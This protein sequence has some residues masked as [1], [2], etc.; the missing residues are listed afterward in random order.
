MLQ[1]VSSVS[2]AGRRVNVHGR[3]PAVVEQ[4]IASVG[5]PLNAHRVERE[6]EAQL[7]AIREALDFA[8]PAATKGCVESLAARCEHVPHGTPCEQQDSLMQRC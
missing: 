6:R 5:S 3:F 1:Q 8:E 2:T 7:I 4:H